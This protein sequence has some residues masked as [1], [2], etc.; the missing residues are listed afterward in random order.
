M[1]D[2][3]R[4]AEA[5]G[6]AVEPLRGKRDLRQQHEALPPLPQSFGHALEIGLGLARA[7]NAVEQGDGEGARLDAGHDM[8][9][10]L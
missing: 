4:H 1:P 8:R 10:R 2:R 6:E 5:A 9:G 3:G 7:G